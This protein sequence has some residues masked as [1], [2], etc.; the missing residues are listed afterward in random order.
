MVYGRGGG[1]A[2]GGSVY[3]TINDQEIPI[4]DSDIC[5]KNV[6]KNIQA[7]ETISDFIK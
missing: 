6:N 4:V 3:L 5:S 2:K 1:N 7:Q